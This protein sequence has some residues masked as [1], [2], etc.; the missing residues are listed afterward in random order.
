MAS[1]ANNPIG[2]DQTPG[3]GDSAVVLPDVHS[4]T[5][6]PRRQ[7]WAIVENERH[8]ASGRHRKQALG[9]LTYHFIRARLQT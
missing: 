2:A 7:F 8:I 9:R 4:V 3:V 5:R 6:Q 1:H